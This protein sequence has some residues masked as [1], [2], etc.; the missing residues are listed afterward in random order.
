[1]GGFWAGFCELLGG[2][3]SIQSGNTESTRCVVCF[4]VVKWMSLGQNRC[5]N[6]NVWYKNENI[7]INTDHV[8]PFMFTNTTPGGTAVK[9]SFLVNDVTEFTGN[10]KPVCEWCFSG[11]KTERCYLCEQHIFEFTGKVVLVILWQFTGI[12]VW[13]GLLSTECVKGTIKIKCNRIYLFFTKTH[14]FATGGLYSPLEPCEACFITNACA[15]F[16]YFWTVEQKH[17]LQ[18]LTL[19]RARIIFN[20]TL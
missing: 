10:L 18:I 15:L 4:E 2:K 16:D 3:S 14:W 20:I 9:R 5:V 8:Y 19:V 1:M 12:T 7:N 6:V 11:K 17:P 13:K